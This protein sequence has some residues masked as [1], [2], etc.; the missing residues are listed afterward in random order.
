MNQIFIGKSIEYELRNQER[1][2]VWLARKLNCNRTN[3]YKIF[4]RSTIDTEL[5]L[6]ISNVL[7]RN[8]FEE[9][10]NRLDFTKEA[11]A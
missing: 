11:D 7:Q 10:I 1:S 3:I 2:V 9:Y 6:R 4:N 5:L 8:F